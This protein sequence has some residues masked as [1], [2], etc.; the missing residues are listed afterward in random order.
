LFHVVEYALCIINVPRQVN[1]LLNTVRPGLISSQV[2]GMEI[3]APGGQAFLDAFCFQPK[4][5][6][7]PQFAVA[8]VRAFRPTVL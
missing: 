6:I 7:E 2:T 4:I 3:V 1:S 8:L 5:V